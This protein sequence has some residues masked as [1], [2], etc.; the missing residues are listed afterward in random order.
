[1]TGWMR[2][3][4]LATPVLAGLVLLGCSGSDSPGGGSNAS[5][6]RPATSG[7]TVPGS[8]VRIEVTGDT[9]RQVPLGSVVEMVLSQNTASTGYEWIQSSEGAALE[10]PTI[11]VQPPAGPPGSSGTATY[12][13]KAVARGQFA[14]VFN[15][16][17]PGADRTIANTGKT[18]RVEI[19]VT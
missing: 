11:S 4:S 7:T 9:S 16:I 6:A 3:S 18:Y 19:T 15:E 13:F 12:T 8:T 10:A 1:M 5:T 2:R 14:S 17:G